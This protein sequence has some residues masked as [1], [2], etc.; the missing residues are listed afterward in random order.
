MVEE[1]HVR[2]GGSSMG[3]CDRRDG[4][5]GVITIY[6]GLGRFAVAIKGMDGCLLGV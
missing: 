6:L 5:S 1:Y 4:S 2:E 3:C